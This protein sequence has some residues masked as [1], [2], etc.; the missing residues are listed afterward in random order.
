MFMKEQFLS[1]LARNLER[2][3]ARTHSAALAASASE[4]TGTSSSDIPK[5]SRRFP[6]AFESTCVRDLPGASAASGSARMNRVAS[7]KSVK[8]LWSSAACAPFAAA[9]SH[10]CAPPSAPSPL[11]SWPYPVP[12]AQYSGLWPLPLFVDG[13]PAAFVLRLPV[14][15]PLS[16]LLPLSSTADPPTAPPTAP[17]A[18]S[19]LRTF[20]KSTTSSTSPPSNSASYPPVAP[21]S[22]SIAVSAAYMSTY[23]EGM[24]GPPQL[25]PHAASLASDV[26]RRDTS[27]T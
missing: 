19:S 27:S 2:H 6:E 5:I 11:T 4:S 12:L 23:R 18:A 14:I 15:L 26:S 24:S 22:F 21:D 7:T 25:V 20:A 9:A 13:S 1:S 16:P 10:V 3:D 8:T 17:P